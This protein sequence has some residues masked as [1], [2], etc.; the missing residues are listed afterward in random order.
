MET[1]RSERSLKTYIQCAFCK[2]RADFY[3]Q[4][5]ECV[6]QEVERCNVV[7]YLRAEAEHYGLLTDG[8]QSTEMLTALELADDIEQGCHVL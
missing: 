8:S 1:D 7:A 3:Y 5:R 2:G 6:R 4:C